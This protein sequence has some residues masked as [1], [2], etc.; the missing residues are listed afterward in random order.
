MENMKTESIILKTLFVSLLMAGFLP[1]FIHAGTNSGFDLSRGIFYAQNETSGG[2]K[3]SA[4]IGVSSRLNGSGAAYVEQSEFYGG[5]DTWMDARIRG[6]AG[7]AFSY[8]FEIGVGLL[9]AKRPY[10]GTYQYKFDT[11]E[12]VDIYGSPRSYFPYAYYGGWDGFVFPLGEM[13]SAGPSGWP[14]T[15]SV[16][17]SILCEISGS[18]FDDTLFWSLGRK[19]REWAAMVQ[20]SSLVLNEAAQ[21]FFGFELSFQPF[22]WVGFSS[23]TG[24]LE[25]FNANGIQTSSQTF[26]NA[27][28]L[29]SV[30]FDFPNLFHIDF[31]TS[32]V[33]P[34][35]FELG[36]LFPL[37]DKMLY[38]NNIGDFDNIGFF[39]NLKLEKSGLG[40]I[41]GS[42]FV[43]EM[44]F[45]KDF[46]ILDREMYA[47]QF[48][49]NVLLPML[50]FASLDLS[51]TKIE[52]YC[53]THQK[54]DVPWYAGSMEEAYTN[55]GY[56]LG[57][58]LPPNS[59]E[60]KLRFQTMLTRGTWV[61]AQFQMIRHG[62]DYG[63]RAV[64]GSSYLSELA[65]SNRSSDPRLRKF[66]LHDGAYQWAHII[67]GSITHSLRKLPI[68]LSLEV[69]M[70]F[71]YWTD[72]DGIPND[73]SSYSYHSIDTEQYPKRTGVIAGMG[74]RIY[75]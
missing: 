42:F 50:P 41:W 46:F 5:F 38:Q 16:G 10:L 59:D 8:S 20:G 58:Y 55:H 53:Y 69:G 75:K 11:N 29:S 35:R 62:A 36:Y 28:S 6:D 60:I 73:G 13:N 63:E 68:E 2:T 54:T 31:G 40:F 14:D 34:K 61:K 70:V 43:D 74:V 48:G 17:F 7:N 56:G 64:D 52:P 45:E 71:S 24:M 57:Y 47:W 3:L 25:Y 33:W 22:R 9:S 19:R 37:I 30:Y 27:F 39:G 65:E 1:V 44:N 66:F 32:S 15:P 21:P 67:K 23:L 12:T 72:I 49:F 18:A 26:Q 51:Y 4:E